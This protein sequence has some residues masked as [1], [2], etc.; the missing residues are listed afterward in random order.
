ME[1]S[2]QYPQSQT[3]F[4]NRRLRYFKIKYNDYDTNLNELEN[5]VR[6]ELKIKQAP[7]WCV[8]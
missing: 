3:Q 6:Q 4:L 1:P 7:T 8:D 5:V 2:Y